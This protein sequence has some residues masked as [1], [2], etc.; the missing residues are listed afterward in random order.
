[1]QSFVLE[2]EALLMRLEVHASDQRM[3]AIAGFHQW[4]RYEL[5][6]GTT[7]SIAFSPALRLADRA[8]LMTA[9]NDLGQRPWDDAFIDLTGAP[10]ISWV[11][12]PNLRLESDASVWVYYEQLPSA[13]CTEPWTGPPNS[14]E[15]EWATVVT[16]GHPLVLNFA[17]RFD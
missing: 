15:T 14:I 8:G 2:K 13:F 5:T 3:P 4:F 10:A 16:P 11:G 12:G 6:D 1:V 17:I 7:A 9:T